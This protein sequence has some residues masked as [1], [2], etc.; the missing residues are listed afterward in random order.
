MCGDDAGAAAAGAGATA[1]FQS[2]SCPW[3]GF[4]GSVAL[5]TSIVI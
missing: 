1:A 2:F 4:V 5:I 3:V